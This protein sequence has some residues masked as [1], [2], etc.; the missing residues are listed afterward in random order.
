M[1]RIQTIPDGEDAI[2][3]YEAE[4]KQRYY[5]RQLRK[6]KRLKAGTCDEEN[7]EIASKKVKG[8]EKVLKDHLEINKELR[9]NHYRE[10]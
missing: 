9:R 8:L 6:W 4:Q 5:E 7:K 10:K 3:L 1:T 2:K